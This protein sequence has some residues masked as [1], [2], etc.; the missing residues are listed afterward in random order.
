MM[1]TSAAR[2]ADI[3]EEPNAGFTFA[4]VTG[5]KPRFD[6]AYRAF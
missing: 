2:D 6:P 3:I 1:V 4:L 5:A